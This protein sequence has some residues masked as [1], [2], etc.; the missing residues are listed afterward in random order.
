MMLIITITIIDI[1][2]LVYCVILQYVYINIAFSLILT[3][4]NINVYMSTA[5][6]T[7]YMK[8]EIKQK[9]EGKNMMKKKRCTEPHIWHAGTNRQANIFLSECHAQN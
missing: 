3:S 7:F 4:L 5:Y 9:L 2:V 1:P 6:L 8:K